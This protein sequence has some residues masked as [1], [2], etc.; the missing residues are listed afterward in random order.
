MRKTFILLVLVLAA[1]IA[2]RIMFL[3]AE[4]KRETISVENIWR[5]EGRPV[6]VFTAKKGSLELY[7]LV[8]GI[9]E[10]GRIKVDIAPDKAVLIRPGRG[11]TAEPGISGTVVK[12]SAAPSRI[13]G[14]HSAELKVESGSAAPGQII[15]P[16]IKTGVIENTVLVLNGC[17]VDGRYIWVNDEGV[18]RKRKAAVKARNDRYTAVSGGIEAGERAVVYYGEAFTEGEKART[19]KEAGE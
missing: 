13:S 17:V 15:R 8:S 1:S 11:F 14:L 19:H 18:L 10:G 3:E 9:H 16:R 2:G 6:D 5:A 12:V 7:T 4:K